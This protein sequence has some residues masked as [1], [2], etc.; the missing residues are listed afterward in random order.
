MKENFDSLIYCSRIKLLS[1]RSIMV[2]LSLRI[3][4]KVTIVYQS[5]I[6]YFNYQ[7][8]K[9]LWYYGRISL[10]YIL[11][12]LE[13]HLHSSCLGKGPCSV[14]L[15]PFLSRPF[16]EGVGMTKTVDINFNF[17]DILACF[18]YNS[19]RNDVSNNIKALPACD[20]TNSFFVS[21]NFFSLVM[22]PIRDIFI[23]SGLLN[24]NPPRRHLHRWAVATPPV[25]LKGVCSFFG[26]KLGRLHVGQHLHN[27]E[28]T[29]LL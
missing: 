19:S 7:H 18:L 24:L 29:S 4:D 15:L 11:E 20:S 5:V 2:P 17:I 13:Y 28:L 10:K 21:R 26:E 14:S 22:Y 9:L 12:L 6:N 23:F 27:W 16:L 25:P 1:I 8:S 3:N